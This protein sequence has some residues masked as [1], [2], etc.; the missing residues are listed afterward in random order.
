MLKAVSS[1]CGAGRTCAFYP[2]RLGFDRALAAY[3]QALALDPKVGVKRKADQ[4]R[5]VLP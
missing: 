5:K 1:S 3:E 4:L 2:Q